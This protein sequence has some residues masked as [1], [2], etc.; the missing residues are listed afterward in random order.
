[1][2]ASKAPTISARRGLGRVRDRGSLRAAGDRMGRRR[3][4]GA[5]APAAALDRTHA[6]RLRGRVTG[7]PDADRPARTS[8]SPVGARRFGA[9]G[10]THRPCGRWWRSRPD[11]RRPRCRWRCWGC[12]PPD[13]SCRGA[14]RPS[15]ASRSSARSRRWPCRGSTPAPRACGR[16]GPSRSGRPRPS[17][18]RPS[19]RHRGGPSTCSPCSTGNT[20]C[21]NG[22]ARRRRCS[23]AA[24]VA[25]LRVPSLSTR[26]RVLVETALGSP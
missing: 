24:G 11:A 5:P 9:R 16:R 23:T 12:L 25:S 3:G 19:S 7:G 21:A 10:A 26:E 13:S 15:A 6:A 1:M 4:A 20:A 2:C 18:W 14:R 22:W 17:R 8:R